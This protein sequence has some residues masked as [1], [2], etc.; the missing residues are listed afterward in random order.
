[1][2]HFQ[3]EQRRQRLEQA[4]HGGISE[5]HL[6]LKIYG[7]SGIKLT[8]CAPDR[9][10][11]VYRAEY[12]P[13][14]LLSLEV[15]QPGTYCVV[16]FE[17]TM[18]EALVYIAQYRIVFPVPLPLT[19]QPAPI[20]YSPK[21]FTGSCHILRARFATPEEITRRRNLAFNPYDH[22]FYGQGP[23]GNGKDTGFYPHATSNIEPTSPGFAPRTA[24]DGVFENG[25]HLIWPYQAW[26]NDRKPEAELTIDF[27]RPVCLDELRLTLRADF[28]HD[29]WWTEADVRFSDGSHEH[30]KLEK[31]AAPQIFAIRPRTVTSLTLYNLQKHE[32]PALYTAL[33]QLEAW[34]TEAGPDSLKKKE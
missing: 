31:S 32:D 2:E 27:G 10:S 19:E 23:M 17:D 12:K 28:P 20:P 9:V 21:S 8:V 34:G 11:A 30:L 16:Q 6:A 24:I 13:G 18:P 29:G 5:E 14:D 26:S 15:P 1:M 3:A 25:A 7:Q 22:T 4:A 33:T